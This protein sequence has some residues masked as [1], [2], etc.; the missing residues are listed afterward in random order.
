MNVQNQF[1]AMAINLVEGMATYRAGRKR[2]RPRGE[3]EVE[4]T[5]KK[6]KGATENENEGLARP[7]PDN[8]KSN[9]AGG[10][11]VAMELES[12]EPPPV[13]EHL[14][15]GINAVTRALEAQLAAA[16]TPIIITNA[17]AP[18][19]LQPTKDTTMTPK[20]T[21]PH[22]KIKLIF[23]CRAD[24]D[25]PLLVAHIPP[26]V[27]A[28]NAI[29]GAE[30]AIKL[31]PLPRGAEASL[32]DAL[33]LRRVAVLAVADSA[34]GF[35]LFGDLLSS[36]P[37]LTAPW[38]APAP[39]LKLAPTR[40]KQ[41]RTSAPRDLKGAKEERARGLAAAKLKTKA[42]IGGK[43][44]GRVVSVVSTVVNDASASGT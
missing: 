37:T 14:I 17:P 6:G 21:S 39:T 8:A 11:D 4:H 13:L 29:S 1:L 12:V 35:G 7:Q 30:D 23:I 32:A 36:V 22:P 34:T 28:H 41:V 3:G 38:R 44:K 18:N 42:K 9:I 33:G 15:T 40:V 16:R 20:Q 26:L 19:N 24:I 2:K 10:N 27:A 31:V 25:P 5:K 43:G